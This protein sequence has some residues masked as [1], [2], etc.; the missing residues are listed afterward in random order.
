MPGLTS[1]RYLAPD[2]D[3]G[4]DDAAQQATYYLVPYLQLPAP[5]FMLGSLDVQS[6]ERDKQTSYCYCMPLLGGA[7]QRKIA[8]PASNLAPLLYGLTTIWPLSCSFHHEL[9]LALIRRS[10]I[11]PQDDTSSSSRV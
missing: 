4:K 10:N 8:T 5:G 1:A 2:G 11:L 7:C 6:C 3:W 9:A